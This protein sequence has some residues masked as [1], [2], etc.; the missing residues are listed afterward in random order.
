M[1]VRTLIDRRKKRSDDATPGVLRAFARAL[2][3]QTG[4]GLDPHRQSRRTAGVAELAELVDPAGL[5]VLLTDGAGVGQGLLALDAAGAVTLVERM[6]LGRLDARAPDP[7]PVSTLDAALLEDLWPPFL[8][9]LPDAATL[10]LGPRVTDLRML[11]LLLDHTRLD[12]TLCEIDLVQG[13]VSRNAHLIFA[14]APSD[15]VAEP[16]APP[17]HEWTRK[18]E[19]AVM[20]APVT[21]DAVLARLDWSLAQVLDLHKG[22]SIPLPLGLLEEI[23]LLPL[24]GPHAQGRLGQ[25]RGMR[26]IR[27]TQG[28]DGDQDG[29][30]AH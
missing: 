20:A 13:D 1:S 7:R 2:S 15:P 27:L 25:Y 6:T 10:I 3:N 11:P 24:D 4:L 28:F 9:L 8:S 23:A 21:V 22:Q 14:L 26:A 12:L 18:L 5:I 16:L 30:I 29:T 19:T 17:D